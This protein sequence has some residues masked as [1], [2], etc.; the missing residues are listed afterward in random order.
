MAGSAV[1]R[2]DLDPE[3][4]PLPDA[5]PSGTDG[6]TLRRM[7]SHDRAVDALLDLIEEGHPSPTAR[8]VAD[9]ARISIRTVFRLTEDIESLH[10][11]AVAHQTVRIAPLFVRLPDSGP[12]RDRIDALV[13]NRA[14]VF[15]K[16][17]PVRRV[18]E[19]LAV[20][21]EVI[22]TELAKN[23][24]FLSSQIA[25]VFRTEIEAAPSDT[26]AELRA[27]VEVLSGWPTW[28]QLRRVRSLPRSRAEQA[29]KRLIEAAFLSMS[30]PASGR[31]RRR[32]KRED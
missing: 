25:S 30:D 4:P 21:S 27:C 26:R 23:E 1:T 7:R 22:S 18:A 15:E 13:T 14:T 10:A 12:L 28:D 29:M 11:T 20:T 16:I 31:R 32:Q 19:R 5:K 8:Q 24:R 3:D 6:R 9:R 2:S 17:A